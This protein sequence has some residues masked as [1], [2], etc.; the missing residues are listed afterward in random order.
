MTDGIE[1]KIEGLDALAGKLSALSDV[2]ESKAGRF[3]LRKAANVIRDRA[4]VNAARVD[5]PQTP[6]AIHQNIVARF[7]SKRYRQTGELA[8][9][10]GVL[11]GARRT[12]SAAA[13][14][15]AEQ[16][17]KRHGTAPLASQGELTGSGKGNP[18]GDTW[19]W[20]FLEFGTEHAEARPFM[21]PAMNGA[22]AEVVSTF[23]AELEK[24]VDRAIRRM[25]R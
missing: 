15:K 1:I 10:V 16:R 4:R 7:S 5:D 22:D 25:S 11:G 6:E 14:R 3:A 2:V 21:R 8:F 13:S 23:A 24:A 19:Y 9:R 12:L 20:R 18:G 17:R